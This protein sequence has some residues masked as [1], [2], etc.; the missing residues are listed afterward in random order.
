MTDQPA[1]ASSKTHPAIFYMLCV[2]LIGTFLWRMTITATEYPVRSA[3]V[4]EMAIDA[5]LIAGLIGIRK[6]GPQILLVVALIA[7]IGVFGIRLHSDASW[8]T[9]HWH[10]IFDKR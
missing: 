9:G 7:G 4:L 8:W 10:Y 6:S 2:L 5:G 3:Q 1:P